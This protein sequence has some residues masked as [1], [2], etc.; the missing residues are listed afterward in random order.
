MSLKTATV[1]KLHLTH[2]TFVWSFTRVCTHVFIKMAGPS[3]LPVTDTTFVWPL[4]CMCHHVC[5]KMLALYKSFSHT[6]HLY[7]DQVQRE[8]AEPPAILPGGSSSEV[9]DDEDLYSFLNKPE[10]AGS[11]LS[12]E[13]IIITSVYLSI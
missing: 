10:Q 7:V 6:L 4:T 9:E 12:D 5:L 8:V 3:Q 11:S 2:I 13:V 1:S